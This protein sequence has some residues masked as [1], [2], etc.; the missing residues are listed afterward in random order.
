MCRKTAFFPPVSAGYGRTGKHTGQSFL[1][2]QRGRKADFSTFILTVNLFRSLR[3]VMGTAHDHNAE[4]LLA[5]MDTAA[6]QFA[7]LAP[8][9]RIQEERPLLL[10]LVAPAHKSRSGLRSF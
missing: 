7:I 3:A 1:A 5:V 2:A 9:I 10:P 8:T 6:A 4:T